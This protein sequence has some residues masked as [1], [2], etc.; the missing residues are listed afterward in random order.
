MTHLT[1][2]PRG[3]I[4]ARAV[5]RVFTGIL[6]IAGSAYLVNHGL[7]QPTPNWVEIASIPFIWAAVIAAPI[8]AHQAWGAR[9]R[10]ATALLM[11]AAIFGSAYTLSSTIARQSEGADEMRT[12]AA[13]ITRQRADINQRLAEAR[14]NLAKYRGDQARECASG[15]GRRC[16]GITYTVQTWAAAIEGYERRIARL[17]APQ[18]PDAGDRR[19]AAFVALLPNVTSKI[20]KIEDDVRLVK[21]TLFGIFLEAAAL[22]FAF[23]G[24]RPGNGGASDVEP[25]L[26]PTERA[27]VAVASTTKAQAE[28]DVVRLRGVVP[29]QDDLA[30]RWNVHKGTVSKWMRDFEARGLVRRQ[31]AGH[32]MS[33]AA[34][35]A[36]A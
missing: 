28:A 8:V 5:A 29:S 26:P 20:E 34:I 33:V 11:V 31:R 10:T 9:E 6:W 13:E 4:A 30:D 32:C 24:F 3:E 18:T 19:I 35:R 15:K 14:D 27:T 17:P 12:R 16:D 25:K 7:H 1:T 36:V 22:A 2:P 23:Y 21:P